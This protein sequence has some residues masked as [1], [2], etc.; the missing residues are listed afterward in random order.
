MARSLRQRLAPFRS[1]LF[2]VTDNR[3]ERSNEEH[4]EIVA[5]ILANDGSAAA[6][7]MSGHAANSAMNVLQHLRSDRAATPQESAA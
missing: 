5:A 6:R 7:A 3:F 4:G 2:Y 1:R